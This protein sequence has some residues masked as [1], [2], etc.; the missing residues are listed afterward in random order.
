MAVP[1]Q[2]NLVRV[3]DRYWVVASVRES[4]RPADPLSSNGWT[5]HHLVGLVPIDDKGSPEPLSVFWE[6]EP[7][8]EICPQSQMPD[9]CGGLDPPD[10]FARSEPVPSDSS[11][12]MLH[13]RRFAAAVSGDT[14]EALLE[15]SARSQA[16]VTDQL[17]TQARRAAGLLVD[18]ISR[19]DRDRHGTLLSGV[20]PSEVYEAAVTVMMR[21]VFLLVAEENSLL[22]ADNPHYQTLYSIRC[23]ARDARTGTLRRTQKRSR[24]APRPGIGC[25]PPAVRCTRGS[26]TR[27]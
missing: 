25:W 9:L 22:P 5:R 12:S 14:P 7:G 1:E 15:E 4:T 8:T 10:A 11:R 3:R 13:A 18:A 24:P 17:G 16:E 26:S 27:N 2:G 23:S 6:I 20:A 19:A 21:A